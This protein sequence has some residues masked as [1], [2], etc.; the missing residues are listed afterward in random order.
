M[1]S[2]AVAFIRELETIPEKL[3][4]GVEAILSEKVAVIVTTLEFETISSESVS[5]KVT[6]GA[7]LSIIKVILSVPEYVLPDKF[8]PET[9]AVVEVTVAPDTVQIYSQT[10]AEAVALINTLEIMP[11]KLIVGVGVMDSEKVAVM[12]TTSEL[13]IILSLSEL[14]K[15]TEGVLLLETRYKNPFLAI[16]LEAFPMTDCPTL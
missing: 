12:V 15:V 6:V 8:E 4:V 13:E 3:I 5:V 10:E 9:V 11:L 2:E 14:L 16:P 1:V 7:V